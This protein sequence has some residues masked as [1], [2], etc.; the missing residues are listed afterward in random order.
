[1]Q[2]LAFL[3]CAGEHGECTTIPDPPQLLFDWAATN[4]DDKIAWQY[5]GSQSTATGSNLS[6]R[7]LLGTF[8]LVFTNLSKSDRGKLVVQYI[9]PNGR[10][11]SCDRIIEVMDII[12]GVAEGRGL[13][14]SISDHLKTW[15]SWGNVAGLR[16]G[17]H[18]S[19]CA[20]IY[21]GATVEVSFT[22]RLWVRGDSFWWW[23][24]SGERGGGDEGVTPHI[25]TNRESIGGSVR[26]L[27]LTNGPRR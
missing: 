23:A 9:S 27:D 7:P 20:T 13:R 6:I 2:C 19:V 11:D 10:G 18:T 12:G 3:A 22:R 16:D 26:S 5:V 15:N 24:K 21:N 17:W 8:P 4:R 14:W 1:M 25:V